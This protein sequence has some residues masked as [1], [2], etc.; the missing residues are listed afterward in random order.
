MDEDTRGRLTDAELKAFF[1][2]LFLHGFAGADVL[3]EI[4]PEGWEKSPLLACFHPSPEQAFQESLQMH[5]NIEGLVRPRREREPDNPKLAPKPEPTLAAVRAEWQNTPVKTEEEVA[6]LVGLC[7]WDVF[8]DNH[9]VIAADGRVVDIGSFRGAAGFIAE[10]VS[11]P[12]ED[13]WNMD[14]IQFYMGTIWIGQRADLIPVYRMIF[15]RLK[16]LAADWEFHFSELGLVDMAPLREAWEKQKT[17]DYS[18]SEAFAK[19][20]EEQ[21]RQE[22]LD[23]VRAEL[24]EGNAQARREALD[25]P[26][27][28]TVRAYEEVFGREPKGWPPV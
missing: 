1:D 27:P 16:A 8:S 23:R 21:E 20:H 15:R 13:L 10:C 26:P 25:L 5:R 17:E 19:E 2:R 9:E 11:G 12:N 7:L 24:D 18:P 22:E 3:A 14:Y 4:A 6:Q 28:A